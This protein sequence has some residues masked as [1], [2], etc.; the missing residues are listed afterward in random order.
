MYEELF[1]SGE[2][3]IST[4]HPRI[5]AAVSETVNENHIKAAVEAIREKINRKDE[6]A[7]NRMFTGLVPGYSRA[8]GGGPAKSRPGIDVPGPLTLTEREAVHTAAFNLES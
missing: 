8:G 4:S 7:L 6:E 1:N 3:H 5:R 2:S